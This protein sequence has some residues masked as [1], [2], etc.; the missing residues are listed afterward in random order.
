MNYQPCDVRIRDTISPYRA[1]AS[2]KINIKIM[3]TNIL[4]CCALA[5]TPASPTIPMASPAAKE[6]KPQHNPEAK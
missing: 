3:P 6:L 5:L 4:S 2:P 1:K